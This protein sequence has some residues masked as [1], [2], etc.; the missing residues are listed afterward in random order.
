[1]TESRAVVSS[2]VGGG[3]GLTGKWPEKPLEAKETLCVV[4]R[5]WT[6][7]DVFIKTHQWYVICA[8]TMQSKPR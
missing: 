8:F 4:I 2:G 5:V 6:T 7:D 1:M 3:G